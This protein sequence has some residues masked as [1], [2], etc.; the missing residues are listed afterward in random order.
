MNTTKI[1]LYLKLVAYQLVVFVL[2]FLSPLGY[3][4]QRCRSVEH[5]MSISCFVQ[6][7]K[8]WF[9]DW[10]YFLTLSTIGISF[11]FV[12]SALNIFVFKKMNFNSLFSAVLI[13][14]YGLCFLLTAGLIGFDDFIWGISQMLF[15]VLFTFIF[16]AIYLRKKIDIIPQNNPKR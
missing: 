4:E 15:P 5:E 10:D 8:N 7:F 16:F 1:Y 3:R 2:T 13:I 6:A 9:M 14:L 12:F 11:G